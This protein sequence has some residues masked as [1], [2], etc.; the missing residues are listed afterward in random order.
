MERVR[1]GVGRGGGDGSEAAQDGRRGLW[2]R[3][4]ISWD[5]AFRS[6]TATSGLKYKAGVVA[7]VNS[8]GEQMGF[9]PDNLPRFT[10]MLVQTLGIQGISGI[11]IGRDYEADNCRD[12]RGGYDGGS[13]GRDRGG[14]GRGG[15]GRG[16]AH[17]GKTKAEVA[18]EGVADSRTNKDGGRSSSRVQ[19]W[20]SDSY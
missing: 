5:T 8:L 17:I 18:T 7:H 11:N 12:G 2:Y 9:D 15:N 4:L 14:Y 10:P 16:V 20:E 1:R 19:R 13:D 6:N 3:S